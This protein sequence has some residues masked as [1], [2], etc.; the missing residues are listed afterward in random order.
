MKK[1]EDTTDAANFLARMKHDTTTAT[2][3]IGDL[4][5]RLPDD[6]FLERLSMDE[7]GKVDVQGQSSNAA[8][9][10]ENLKKSEVLVDPAFTGTIQT[11]PRHE[12]KNVSIS[13]CRCASIHAMPRK[14]KPARLL[15]T[16]P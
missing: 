10:I 11:D 5:Q 2:E 4:T 16:N 7:K 15:A 8:K 13:V 9:L 1:L 3:I 12:K 14:L 6:A